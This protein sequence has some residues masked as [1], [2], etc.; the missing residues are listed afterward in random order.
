MPK[1]SQLKHTD[2][3]EVKII[4]IP[5]TKTYPEG[6][7]VPSGSGLDRKQLEACLQNPGSYQRELRTLSRYLYET[8]APYRRT[9]AQ[10][11]S[12]LDLSSL[13]VIPLIAPDTQPL[14]Q[15]VLTQY[16]RTLE[17]LESMDLTHEFYK[18]YVTA[19]LEDAA[20]GYVCAGGGFRIRLL[21]ADLCRINKVYNDSSPAFSC[22]M[23]W[24]ESRPNLLDEYGPPFTQMWSEYQKDTAANRW[25]EMPTPNGVCLK[26]RTEDPDRLLP[27]CMCLFPTLLDYEELR[28]LEAAEEK[29]SRQLNLPDRQPGCTG[30]SLSAL[31]QDLLREIAAAD[32]RLSSAILFSQTERWLNSYL[33]SV[34]DKPARVCFTRVAPGTKDRL[35]QSLRD[36][37]DRG[38]PV[39]LLLNSLNGFSALQTLSLRYLE[40]DCLGLVPLPGT[41][42]GTDPQPPAE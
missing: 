37:A 34:L 15:Q 29:L 26:I 8:S 41:D 17:V 38:L 16:A 5:N 11:V 22:D 9:I 32:S 3:R 42:S 30:A 36:D 28:S 35:R 25:Q 7:P 10:R 14:P 6:S 4:A 21:D 1:R 40:Q 31:R 23:S 19:W 33:Q 24:F 12:Q 18:L 39:L 13:S 20:F 2:L 27:P